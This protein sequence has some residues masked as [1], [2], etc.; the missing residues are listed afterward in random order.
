MK[1]FSIPLIAATLAFTFTGCGGSS[2]DANSKKPSDAQTSS[3]PTANPSNAADQAIAED[4]VLVLSDFPSGWEGKVSDSDDE[5]A[6]DR[7]IAKC[8]GFDYETY[9][10]SNSGDAESKDFTSS[11]DETI[12]NE[13]TLQADE[14]HAASSFDIASGDKFRECFEKEAQR[15]IEKAAK[16]EGE[17]DFKI[18]KATINELSFDSFGDE[19]VAYR[20]TIPV[21]GQGMDVDIYTDYIVIRVGRAETVVV[22]QST[23]SPFDVDEL[24]KYARVATD[25]L[26]ARLGG[27][28]TE[29]LTPSSPPASS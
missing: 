12:S 16:D 18:G 2:G 11:D 4:S 19:S 24:T 3:S 20:L 26:T 29:T 7:R 14:T 25:R 28:T 23:F 22:A 1:N 10:K 6:T 5:D 15:Y 13:V 9:Y 17:K 21:S 8:A 27:T